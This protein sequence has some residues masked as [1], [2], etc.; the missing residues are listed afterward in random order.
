MFQAT[1][2]RLVLWYTT[3]TAVLLLLFATVSIYM[4]V[5]R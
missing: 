2:R 4:S 3:V 5:V 1:R